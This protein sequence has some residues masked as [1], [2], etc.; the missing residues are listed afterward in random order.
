M[1]FVIRHLSQVA[2]CRA[3]S[4]PVRAVHYRFEIWST[5][6][7]ITQGHHLQQEKEFML[8]REDTWHSH[9]Y[10][11]W[12]TNISCYNTVVLFLKVGVGGCFF[13]KIYIFFV[14]TR[15]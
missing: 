10:L 7:P 5:S 15:F 8:T 3:L 13:K 1:F 2:T 14:F 9:R 6:A 12:K 4:Q 11:L